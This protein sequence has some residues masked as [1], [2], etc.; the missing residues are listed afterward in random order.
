MRSEEDPFEKSRMTLAEHLDELRRRLFR[1]VVAVTVALVVGLY[2][3][4]GVVNLVMRPYHQASAMLSEHWLEK[5][6]EKVKADPS[7]APEYFREGWPRSEEL[8][9]QPPELIGITISEN[10]LFGLKIAF[11]FALVLGGP[12]LIWEMWQFIAAGLYSH[13][14]RLV[15][16]YF[17]VSVGMFVVG[18]LFGYFLMVPYAIYF[19]N[20]DAYGQ[21]NV[22][23]NAYLTFLQGLCLA[24]GVVFQ[25]PLVMTYLGAAGLV[26]PRVLTK[27]RGH[28]I[29]GAFVLAAIL[30]PPDPVTQ[31]MLGIP[32][33][34]L[35]ELGILGT[36]IAVRRARARGGVVPSPR[37]QEPR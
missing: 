37:G 25:L 33:C 30:T 36:R 1:G 13:E 5:A 20:V 7:L 8:L 26:E 16:A 29:V 35:Y 32:L 15:Y 28:F 24:L 14:R 34:A 4:D 10:F 6:R 22:T 27:Y 23:M 18:I 2:F 9:R 11:Y 19:L 17:P 12:I 3:Q 31:L 21:M